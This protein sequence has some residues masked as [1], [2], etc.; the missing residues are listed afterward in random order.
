[1]LMINLIDED[2]N[3]NEDEWNEKRNAP[4]GVREKLT[5]ESYC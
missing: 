2:E 4:L 5:Q 3:E 1:M